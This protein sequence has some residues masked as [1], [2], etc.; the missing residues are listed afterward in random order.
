MKKFIFSVLFVLALVVVV[1]PA[2]AMQCKQG[3][4]GADECWTDVKVSSAET[5]VV[6]AGTVLIYDFNQDS[7]DESSFEVRVAAASTDSYRVAGVAQHTIATGDRGSIL[8]RGLGKIR[9][10]GAISSADR[11]FASGTAGTAVAN[12]NND[13]ASAA[14][15]DKQIAFALETKTTSGSFGATLDAFITVV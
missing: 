4:Y 15:H 13:E 7:V 9:T 10:T 1:S 11:L 8:V 2:F 3:N 14:S 6:R 5:N 12:Q